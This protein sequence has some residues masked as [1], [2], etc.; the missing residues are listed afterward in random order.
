MKRPKSNV[1]DLSHDV[2]LSCNMG[3]LIPIM[4][5]DVV[6]GDRFSIQNEHMVRFSPLVSPVMHRINTTTHYWFVPYRLLWPGWEDFITNTPTEG[7]LPAVP[8]LQ[9]TSNS[10]NP[11]AAFTALDDYLGIP[12]P[13]PEGVP[14]QN[15]TLTFT[16]FAHAA[17]QCIVNEY[18]RDQNLQSEI[19]Y[20]LIDGD[21]TANTALRQLRNR[22][23]EHDYFTSALPFAQKGQ[24]VQI[25]VNQNFEDVKVKFA[26]NTIGA[27]N[28][29]SSTV[30][31]A[32]T[33]TITEQG[34]PDNPDVVGGEL[35]AETSTLTPEQTTINDLRRAFRL[36]EWLEKM[37]RGGSRYI[38]QILAHFGVRSSDARLQRPEYIAGSKSPVVISEVLNTTGTEDAPQ[39]SMAGHGIGVAAGNNGSYY[40][41]EH[42][43]IIGIMSVMPRTAYQQG[44]KRMFLKFNDPFEYFWPSFA[45]IGEQEV[46]NQEVFAYTANSAGT[47]GYVPRYAEYKFENNRVAGEFRT[48]LDFWHMGRIFETTPAL[49]G[50]FVEADPTRR[51]FAVTDPTVQ[52]LYCHILNKV[53]A[54][55]PMPKFGT[56]SF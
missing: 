4:A 10:L 2:K 33:Q 44:V 40:A 24:P 12:Q 53:R 20:K 54:V 49:N 48:S 41:E 30:G 26:D 29:W 36:Q 3:E 22:C 18:Y 16:A 8:T 11:N 31:G 25:P 35:Y 6:P 39:G 17:Y 5:T 13:G 47:F 32:A 46:Q 34:V 21:N 19:D 56:P 55:R 51:V 52:T 50:E 15:G 27:D 43:I 45:N 7:V 28:V 38:E 1:F 14:P 37:A 42:G 23:W 9:C